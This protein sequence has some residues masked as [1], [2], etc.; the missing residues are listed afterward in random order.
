MKGYA[1]EYLSQKVVVDSEGCHIFQHKAKS[2]Y[3]GVG[4]TLVGKY[5]RASKAHQLSYLVHYGEYDRSCYV[6]H[7]CDVPS[8]VNPEHLF[9][10]TPKQNTQDMISKGR[11]GYTGMLGEKHHKHKLTENEARFIRV[12]KGFV[13]DS[14]LAELFNVGKSNIN[15]IRCGITWKHI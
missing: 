12:S 15:N 11:R 14:V 9:I 1:L 10:G 6:C 5:F 13:A 4:K 7:R 3:G 8:C 2:S